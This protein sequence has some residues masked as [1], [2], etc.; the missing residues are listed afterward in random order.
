MGPRQGDLC[1]IMLPMQLVGS[2]VVLAGV[3]LVRLLLGGTVRR[4]ADVA[5]LNPRRQR[6]MLKILNLLAIITALLLLTVVWGVD[7]REFQLLVSSVFAVIGVALFAQWS[8][9]SNITSGLIMF[10]S[11]PYR[12]GDRIRILDLEFAKE[13][14]IEDITAFYIRLRMDS[15][16][17]LTYPNNIVLQKGVLKIEREPGRVGG[18]TGVSPDDPDLFSDGSIL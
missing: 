15:G 18:G 9:L 6:V 14:T 16:E 10:F 17:M 12:I 1:A 8:V 3:F 13:A 2:L 5:R 7:R 11:F 4:W